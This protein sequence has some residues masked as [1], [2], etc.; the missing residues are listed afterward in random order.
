MLDRFNE[1]T[2]YNPIKGRLNEGWNDVDTNGWLCIGE[3]AYD[4][5]LSGID[6]LYIMVNPQ[7]TMKWGEMVN[8]VRYT[9]NKDGSGKQIDN[10]PVRVKENATIYPEHYNDEYGEMFLGKKKDENT[11]K[12]QHEAFISKLFKK[13]NDIIIHHNSSYVIRD[14]LV[15]KGKPNGW[16][17]NSDIGIYFW[18]SR[19]SGRDPSGSTSY[20][21]YCIIHNDVLYDFETNDERLS[22]E[23]ALIKYGYV[24]QY[25]NG[26]NEII[27]I[28]TFRQTPI[29]C[30]L[31]KYTGKWYDKDWNE[32]EKPF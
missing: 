29:W 17:N 31:D 26:D 6:K 13:G 11:V 5:W 8:E 32:I 15:K 14:G 20:T 27:V 3:V 10:I 28:N 23:K 25:W 30:I 1:L 19:N 4:P 9:E 18:G 16:S 24:G 12:E 2:R 21:Y 7:K 22:M